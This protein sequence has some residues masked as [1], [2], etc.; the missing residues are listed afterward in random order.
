MTDRVETLVNLL[1]G[2]ISSLEEKAHSPYELAFVC[3]KISA[4]KDELVLEMGEHTDDLTPF[5]WEE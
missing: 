2:E 3:G 1:I 5:M 4:L